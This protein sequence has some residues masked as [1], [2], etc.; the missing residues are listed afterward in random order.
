MSARALPGLV[1]GSSAYGFTVGAAHSLLYARRNLVKLP[2]LLIATSLVCALAY[3]VV[4]RFLCARLAPRQ[5]GALVLGLFRDLSVLLAS[6]APANLLLAWILRHT[7]DGRIGE[8]GL[9]LGLNV[10]F[11]GVAGSLA[12]VRQGRDLLLAARVPAARMVL[13]LALWLGLSLAV[14]G[15]AAF[16]LRPFFGLPASRGNTPPFALGSAPDV[17]G[18]TNFFEAAWQVMSA[19]P[20]PES[21]GGRR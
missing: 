21:W 11:V 6:L 4:A 8:Y 13:V 10:A 2:L 20:L 14:G 19:P 1:A 7:D 15:Q 18:A 3:F 16:Y 5:V 17:R 9:F 12:L